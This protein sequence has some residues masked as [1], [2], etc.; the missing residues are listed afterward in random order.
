MKNSLKRVFVPLSLALMCGGA[1]VFLCSLSTTYTLNAGRK[2]S[3]L[4]TLTS[5]GAGSSAKDTMYVVDNY[6]RKSLVLQ[7]DLVKISGTAGGTITIYGSCNQGTTYGT[8]ALT[9]LNISTAAS[10]TL[11]YAVNSG[12][13]SPYDHYLCVVSDTGT[14]SGSVQLTMYPK[15]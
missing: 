4:D 11:Q 15:N 6:V 7:F 12:S 1:F 14:Q 3:T 13:G 10:Q 5:S 8:T 9:T 2:Q